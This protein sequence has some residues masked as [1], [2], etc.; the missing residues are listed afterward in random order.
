[1]WFEILPSFGIIVACMGLPHVSAY[2][3]NKVV[4]GNSYRRCL[5]TH[6]QEM[7]YLRDR[8]LTD[9]PYKPAGLENIPSQ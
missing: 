5:R 1:M 6:E 8:R 4:I 2:V 7:Q 9:N 3:I